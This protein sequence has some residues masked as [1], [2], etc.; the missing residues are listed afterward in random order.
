MTEKQR[1]G[2]GSGYLRS[3]RNKNFKKE[4]KSVKNEFKRLKIRIR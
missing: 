2:L 4:H 3:H 1:W